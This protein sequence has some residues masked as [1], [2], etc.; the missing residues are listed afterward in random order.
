MLLQP[1]LP[2]LLPRLSFLIPSKFDS[3]PLYLP[4]QIQI[5][6]D[7]GIDFPDAEQ[8]IYEQLLPVGNFAVSV[9]PAKLISH[10]GYIKILFNQGYLPPIIIRLFP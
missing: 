5:I 6:K 9:S 1:P 10:K 7:P 8:T 2:I 3:H 4:L